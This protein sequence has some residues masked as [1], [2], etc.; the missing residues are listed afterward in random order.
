MVICKKLMCYCKYTP[1]LKL[2]SLYSLYY[3]LGHLLHKHDV[4]AYLN[5]VL[6]SVEIVLQ[7]QGVM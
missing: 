5:R 1:I 4:I 6:G 3:F 2:K 7:N